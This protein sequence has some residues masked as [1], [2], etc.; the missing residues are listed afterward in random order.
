MRS[1]RQSVICLLD[2]C[3]SILHSF[4]C[5]QFASLIHPCIERCV[6]SFLRQLTHTLACSLTHSLTQF[7][8]HASVNEPINQSIHW[9]YHFEL[10]FLGDQLGSNY[11]LEDAITSMCDAIASTTDQKQG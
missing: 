1:L 6:H 2:T 10:P 4:V 7:S 9:L 11:R 8:N 3:L 5:V